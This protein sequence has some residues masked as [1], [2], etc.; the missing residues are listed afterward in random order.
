[1]GLPV[2]SIVTP[3]FNQADYLEEC[4]ESVLGQGYPCLEYVIMDGG[5]TDGS[6]DIIKKYEKYLTYWQSRPDDGQYTAITEGFRH[7]TGDIMAWLNSDDKYHPLAFVKAACVF[8]DNPEILW[9]TGRKT[10]WGEKGNLTWI[11]NNKSYYSRRKFL[12]GFFN[13]PYIQQESTFWRRSLWNIAGNCLSNSIKLAGDMELWSRFFRYAQLYTIDTLLGGFRSH[14][15]QRSKTGVDIYL[16]EAATVVEREIQ[17]FS[18]HMPELAGPPNDLVPA[19]EKLVHFMAEYG[20][21]PCYPNHVM[22]WCEYTEDLM[23]ISGNIAKEFRV[24]FIKFWLNELS[25]FSITKSSIMYLVDKNISDLINVESKLAKLIENGKKFESNSKFDTALDCYNE[26][27]LLSK[28]SADA[29]K[30][31]L[32]CLLRLEK[33]QIALTA[34]A[35]ILKIHVYDEGVVEI[36]CDILRVSGAQDQACSI[37]D[38]YLTLN[39][40]NEGIRQL[41]ASLERRI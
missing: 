32:S 20:I 1:M 24:D 21:R 23:Y 18:K 10:L 16:R 29:A 34:L 30:G 17:E 27:F 39:P 2:I 13:K 19:R 25:I 4:I 11:D 37:C 36:S 41:R 40:H 9:V 15:D 5:S 12:E 28:Y 35:D 6:V 3:S 14:G 22:C 38:E 31:F 8:V 33:I 26:A 7:T